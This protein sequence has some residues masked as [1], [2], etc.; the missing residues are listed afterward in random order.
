MVESRVS[1][2]KPIATSQSKSFCERSS[3]MRASYACLDA[4][5]ASQ[6]EVPLFNT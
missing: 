5:S 6:T 2:K 1:M 4:S 3:S